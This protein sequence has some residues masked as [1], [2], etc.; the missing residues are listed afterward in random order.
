MDPPRLSS[1]VA[2]VLFI[3]NIFAPGRPSLAEPKHV[4]TNNHGETLETDALTQDTHSPKFCVS[5]A[6]QVVAVCLD[7]SLYISELIACSSIFVCSRGSS[8]VEFNVDMLEVDQ[9]RLFGSL[10]PGI[11]IIVLYRRSSNLDVLRDNAW[12][13]Q[14]G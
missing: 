14:G 8:L 5:K 13:P 3:V 2:F 1:C 7:Y 9:S 11:S 12:S 6:V 4:S 10:M